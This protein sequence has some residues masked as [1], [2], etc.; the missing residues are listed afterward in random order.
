MNRRGRAIPK[1]FLV[2]DPDTGKSELGETVAEAKQNAEVQGK[3][4]AQIR[5]F[6]VLQAYPQGIEH[7]ELLTSLSGS[8]K[9]RT[10][11]IQE[12]LSNGLVVRSGRGVKGSPFVY[13]TAEV[14][15]ESTKDMKTEVENP[16]EVAESAVLQ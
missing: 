10:T 7:K 12:A 8:F 16:N 2:F 4:A 9:N 5:L 14:P 6:E 13:K 3:K 1:T 15:M 11:L